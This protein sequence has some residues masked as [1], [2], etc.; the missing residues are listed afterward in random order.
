M[1]R[2][3]IWYQ[4][5]CPVMETARCQKRPLLFSPTFSSSLRFQSPPS[6]QTFTT[7]FIFSVAFVLAL[8]PLLY[9]FYFRFTFIIA[10][11]RPSSRRTP[12]GF[13]F[14]QRLSV[15]APPRGWIKAFS[16]HFSTWRR[17]AVLH[18]SSEVRTLSWGRRFL[19]VPIRVLSII[20]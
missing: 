10:I 8:T 15:G 4:F 6:S 11:P 16:K 17:C 14:G 5:I 1:R 7:F 3:L 13:G 18:L 2:L 20:N 9:W 19:K 12:T